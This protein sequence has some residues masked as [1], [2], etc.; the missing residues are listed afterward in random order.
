MLART[1]SVAYVLAL[2]VCFRSALGAEATPLH[3]RLY[4]TPER[5]ALLKQEITTTHIQQWNTLKRRADSLVKARPPVYEKAIQNADPEQLWEREVGNALPTLAMA[6]LLT[7]NAMYKDAVKEWSLAACAYPTWGVSGKTPGT[8]LAAGHLLFGLAITYDWMQSDL[9]SGTLTTLRE[10]LLKRG[11]TMCAAAVGPSA[12]WWTESYLQNHL[13]VDMCGLAAAALAMPEEPMCKAWIEAAQDKFRRTEKALGSDGASHEG[14]GYWGYGTEYLLRYWALSA[15]LLHEDLSSSWWQNTALYRLYLALPS[16][17]WTRKNS[18][19]DF[20]DCPRSDWYGPDAQLFNL[21]HCFHDGYAQWL[22]KSLEQRGVAGDTDPFL[23][24]LWYD[25]TI[26]AK[27]PKDLPTLRDFNDMEIVSARSGWSGDESLVVFK[28]GPPAG[29]EEVAKRFT[30]DP[31]VGHVHPDANH[32]VIFGNGEWLLRADG[33]AR[34]ETGQEN[35]LLIDGE[36]QKG[37]HSQWLALSFPLP[38]EGEPTITKCETHEDYDLMAG[39]ASGAYPSA[40]GLK[41]FTRQLIFIKPS[42]VVVIDDIETA[43]AHELELRFHPEYPVIAGESGVFNAVGEKAR[44]RI[45]N[46][47]PKGVSSKSVDLPALNENGKPFPMHTVAYSARAERWQNVTA[48]SWCSAKEEPSRVQ[49]TDKGNH[50]LLS[51]DGR[52]YDYDLDRDDFSAI[53]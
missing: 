20:A 8:D 49:L 30:K 19:V 10:T 29:H 17:A 4:L 34:K 46:L 41:H 14:V 52:K 51:V 3:P 35:T 36:G 43:G 24:L 45:E 7:G 18:V 26:P 23:T 27:D 21:A 28:C 31:G 48:L 40:S 22:A 16:H 13:W 9:D 6:W 50:W 5:I 11:Q 38:L 37:E 44:L 2:A 15:E 12:S 53:K 32:F 39:E 42:A 33:Y 1:A 47:T 25:P